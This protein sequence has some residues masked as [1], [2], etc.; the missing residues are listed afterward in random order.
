[1]SLKI[2]F[3]GDVVAKL[4]RKGLTTLLGKQGSKTFL[5]TVKKFVSPTVRGIPIIGT[6]IDF[7][8]N[9][10][11]FKEPVGK[12]AF[13][14]IGAGLAAWLGGAIGSIIPGAG[15]FVGAVLGGWAGDALGGLMYDVFFGSRVKVVN[16][17]NFTSI[18]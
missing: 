14:A 2:L 10:L 4:G 13:K 18:I 11:V 6:L 3:I 7:A 9:L 17:Y 15:T 12:A 1:M 5:K 16:R 8:L